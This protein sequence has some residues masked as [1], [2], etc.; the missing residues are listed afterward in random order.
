VTGKKKKKETLKVH[1]EERR[2]GL[3][4][5]IATLVRHLSIDIAFIT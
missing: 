3:A 1:E 4:L 2:H 5:M